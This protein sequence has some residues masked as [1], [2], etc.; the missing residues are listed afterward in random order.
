[1]APA[2]NIV[3]G[4]AGNGLEVQ[5]RR[6]QRKTEG[7]KLCPGDLRETFSLEVRDPAFLRP[8]KGFKTVCLS[9]PLLV[10][11]QVGYIN[12][13]NVQRVQRRGRE[14]SES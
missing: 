11:M 14:P 10:C 12:V 1:M 8:S 3:L 5:H 6:G 2:G 13:D 9:Q 7:F 4:V